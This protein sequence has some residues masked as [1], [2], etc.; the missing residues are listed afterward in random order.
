MSE[1]QSLW[2]IG[3]KAKQIIALLSMISF[4]NLFLKCIMNKKKEIIR[5]ND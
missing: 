1:R 5:K 2:R 3:S 4:E